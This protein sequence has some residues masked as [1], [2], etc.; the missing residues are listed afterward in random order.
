MSKILFSGI[1]WSNTKRQIFD[2]W[3]NTRILVYRWPLSSQMSSHVYLPGCKS[4][5]GKLHC[6][7]H[8]R[9]IEVHSS[10]HRSKVRWVTFACLLFILFIR[11]FTALS[12][13]E[14][15]ER[16]RWFCTDWGGQNSDKMKKKIEDVSTH[17]D[18]CLAV[19]AKTYGGFNMKTSKM[20]NIP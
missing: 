13:A 5:M 7:S 2:Q 11:G 3:A 8:V 4:W 1:L 10:L 16:S 9:T 19:T 6:F 12:H 15:N 14:N 17:Q 20:L 18:L